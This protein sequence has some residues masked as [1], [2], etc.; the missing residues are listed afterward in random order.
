MIQKL[1]PTPNSIT[2]QILLCNELHIDELPNPRIVPLF[3]PN[4]IGKSTVINSLLSCANNKENEFFVERTSAP[5]IVL[6]YCDRKDN[7]RIREPRDMDEAY[8][9]SF[10]N[11]RFNA[12]SISEGQ[13]IVYSIMGLFDIIGT[14]KNAIHNEGK[15]YLVVIDEIDSGMS[16]DNLDKLMRKLKNTA[17]KREDVQVIFSFNNPFILRYFP[18]VLSLYTGQPIHLETIDDMLAEIKAHEKEFRK[19]RYKANGTPKIPI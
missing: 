9:P 7:F 13:S 15:E 6:G 12:N 16:I 5:M 1:T 10:F 11:R 3:G 17:K 8:S 18:D 2:T 19:I 14:G 4:G